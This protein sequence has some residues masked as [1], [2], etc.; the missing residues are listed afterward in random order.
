MAAQSLNRLAIVVC[1]LLMAMLPLVGRA[2]AGDKPVIEVRVALDA[3]SL[4]K[5]PQRSFVEREVATRIADR[6]RAQYRLFAWTPGATTK[7]ATLTARVTQTAALPLPTMDLDWV[8]QVPDRADFVLAVA[9]QRIYEASDMNRALREPEAFR[10]HLDKAV[11]EVLKEG[12]FDRFRDEVVQRIPIARDVRTIP[13]DRMIAI[14][15]LWQQAQLSHEAVLRVSFERQEGNA[16]KR[17]HLD[18]DILNERSADPDKGMVQGGVLSANWDT[19]PLQLAS[20]WNAQLPALLRGAAIWC[21]VAR[22][23]DGSAGSGVGTIQLTP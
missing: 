1:T 22:Y 17:G 7:V 3:A 18:L 11:R 4:D 9:P 8:L 5:M 12:F 19:G 16:V 21:H 20:R 6:F 13:E 23:R 2:A 14:P 10:D 15:L